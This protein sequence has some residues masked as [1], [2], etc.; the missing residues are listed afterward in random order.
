MNA[1][2]AAAVA[3]A[4]PCIPSIAL[5]AVKSAKA[6]AA[7]NHR[8]SIKF[9]FAPL[10][11]VLEPVSSTLR[12]GAA[13]FSANIMPT[14]VLTPGA[15]LA[16]PD[17]VAADVFV[18]TT[19]APSKLVTA[20]AEAEVADVTVPSLESANLATAEV[21]ATADL[22]VPKVNA[23]AALFSG[24]MS[25]VESVAAVT[26]TEDA[27]AADV[28]F[29]TVPSSNLA[30]AEVSATAN[31]GVPIDTAALSSKGMAFVES[32]AAGV[33]FGTADSIT[34]DEEVAASDV[35]EGHIPKKGV[36]VMCFFCMNS[37][38]I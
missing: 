21:A 30:T 33:C 32:A 6:A 36:S 34:D 18:A 5:A 7:A 37:C 22:L 35:A 2:N 11:D 16:S 20:T 26:A 31:I 24:G 28:T 19:V 38:L 13:A 4:N 10:G 12:A 3:A 17:A 14:A 9:S 25:F 27:A 8:V 15:K 1:A 29:P 23:N